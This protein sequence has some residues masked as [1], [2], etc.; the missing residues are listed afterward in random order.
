MNLPLR[1]TESLSRLYHLL[2]SSFPH[3]EAQV[4][5]V[6]GTIALIMHVSQVSQF[7]SGFPV[8]WLQGVPDSCKTLFAQTAFSVAGVA[9]VKFS[10]YSKSF[11]QKLQSSTSLGFYLDDVNGM[12]GATTAIHRINAKEGHNQRIVS[13]LS[14]NHHLSKRLPATSDVIIHFYRSSTTSATSSSDYWRRQN[15]NFDYDAST[16]SP[17]YKEAWNHLW[18]PFP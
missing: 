8:V 16:A 1:R 2:M 10:I 11:L 5:F 9:H 3:C 12:L 15:K 14:R 7:R 13:D 6:F 4:P 17:N 18:I